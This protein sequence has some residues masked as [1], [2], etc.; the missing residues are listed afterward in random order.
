MEHFLTT[1][2]Y[3]DRVRLLKVGDEVRITGILYT[4]RDAAH[5]R[6]YDA[7]KKGEPLPIDLED[8]IL[9]YTGPTPA[10]P[11]R[12]IGSAGPTTS[13]RMD[14]Y[15]PLLLEK[16]GLLGMIGKG[17]RSHKVREAVLRFGAVYL[18]A[19]GGAGALA[20]QCIK[21]SEIV[22]YEDLGTEA[23]RRI[24]VDNFP[25]VVALDSAGGCVFSC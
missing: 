2:L 12:V 10:P 14:D 11:G 17:N 25:A 13:S 23:V 19:I 20:A 6:F 21:S 24:E 4:A 3:H 5:R 9:Y 18:A 16:T 1:P 15:T 22:A 8:Q 7:I